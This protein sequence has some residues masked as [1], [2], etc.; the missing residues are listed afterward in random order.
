MSGHVYQ[1]QFHSVLIESQ[2]WGLEVSEYLHLN[3][4]RVA[5]QGMG[6]QDRK[7]YNAGRRAPATKEE[8]GRW[9]AILRNYRWSSYRAYAGYEH[10]P[11]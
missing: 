3:P 2:S 10:G 8:V 1:G 9:L 6:K 11:E 7:Q 5:G 4:V